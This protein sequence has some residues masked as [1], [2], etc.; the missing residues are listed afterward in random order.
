MPSI[1]AMA[2][3]QM[4]WCDCGCWARRCRLPESISI[5]P[6]SGSGFGAL[7][8]VY[9]I[10][11]QPPAMTRSSMPDMIWAAARFTVVMPEPQ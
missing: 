4:P 2:S 10:I 11:S 8:A 7:E 9:D 5:G 1:V 3:A 6:A